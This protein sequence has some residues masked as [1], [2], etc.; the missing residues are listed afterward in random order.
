MGIREEEVLY[1][2]IAAN[3][4]VVVRRLTAFWAYDNLLIIQQGPET[5]GSESAFA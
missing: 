2:P 3:H 5:A 1:R 4:D